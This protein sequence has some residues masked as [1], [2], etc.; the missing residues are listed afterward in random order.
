MTLPANIVTG[1]LY[2]ANSH[3]YYSLDCCNPEGSHTSVLVTS[4]PETIYSCDDPNKV[5]I[6]PGGSIGGDAIAPPPDGSGY[7]FAGINPNPASRL[8]PAKA[9]PAA[10]LSKLG[11]IAY[12]PQTEKSQPIPSQLTGKAFGLYR[13]DFANRSYWF[14]V[15]EGRA[16]GQETVIKLADL[17]LNSGELFITP[18]SWS[19]Q[20]LR[21]RL[22]NHD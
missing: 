4:T 19:G 12:D 1:F 8:S 16:T 22:I 13:V 15:Y 2:Y 17:P 9:A 14:A 5:P 3:Y 11:T 20:S 10:I 7:E 18:L 21:V 6:N